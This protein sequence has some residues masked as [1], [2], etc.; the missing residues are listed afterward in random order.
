M[1][2]GLV[3]EAKPWTAEDGRVVGLQVALLKNTYVFPWGQFLYAEGTGEEVRA[4]FTTHDVVV[5]GSGLSLLLEDLA[6][7]RV[8]RLREPARTEK[9]TSVPGPHVSSVSVSKAGQAD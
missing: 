7:Q 1:K 3:S 9:F 5:R 2:P 4:T 8:A 6:A